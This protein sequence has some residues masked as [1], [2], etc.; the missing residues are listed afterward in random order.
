MKVIE[1]ECPLYKLGFKHESDKINQHR[2]YELYCDL[3]EKYRGRE[4]MR[5]LEIG[6]GCGHHV[7]G[8]SALMWRE[9]FD[10]KHNTG[11][12]LHEV[13]LDT[14]SHQKCLEDFLIKHGGYE[15][16]N[17]AS[18][19]YLGNQGDKDFMESLLGK[20]GG[21]Y[22][23]IVDDGGHTSELSRNSF[24]VLWK[25]VKPGGLYFIEDLQVYQF[26][27]R[28]LMDEIHGWIEQLATAK[29]KSP[30]EGKDKPDDMMW[31]ACQHEMCVF[32]KK[33]ERKG[34]IF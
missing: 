32:R 28:S 2:F 5:M 25:S 6:F 26:G 13:D 23:I 21:N 31:I 33:P 34:G 9:Y 1:E 10:P 20:S 7:H 14:P 12:I 15:K 27:D 8:S 4:A 22:D 19:V 18:N 24:E 3:L 29:S 17:H 30:V 11:F 16:R